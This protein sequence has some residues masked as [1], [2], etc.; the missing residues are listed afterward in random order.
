MSIRIGFA[1]TGSFCTLERSLEAL[2]Q[3]REQYDDLQ[4]IL[5]E[6]AYATDTRFMLASELVAQVEQICGKPV[7]HT[8]PQV[9][10]IG[11]KGLLDLLIVAPCTGNTLAKLA[12]GITDSSVTMA[13]KAH[14]RNERAVILAVSTND[15]LSAAAKNIGELLARRN[16]YF[17][18]FG[19]DDPV[20]KPRSLVAHMELLPETVSAALWNTQLQPLLRDYTGAVRKL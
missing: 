2:R 19:Q 3:L 1:M 11:P 9:E 12:S 18:P 20:N 15:G 10:P 6:T 5:S 14:M 13:V 7:W 16:I 4:P 17:V 8:I